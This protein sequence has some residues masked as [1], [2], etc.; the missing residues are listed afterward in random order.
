MVRTEGKYDV[1]ENGR[2][3]VKFSSDRLLHFEIM[4]SIMK[5][6]EMEDRKQPF[7]KDIEFSASYQEEGIESAVRRVPFRLFINEKMGVCPSY[8][9]LCNQLNVDVWLGELLHCSGN[10][11]LLFRMKI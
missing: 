1:D 11:D 2:R 5:I 8:T 7:K 6:E 3:E 9:L 10:C 4:E